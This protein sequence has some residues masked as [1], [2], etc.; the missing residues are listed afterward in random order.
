L[1]IGYDYPYSIDL[2]DVETGTYRVTFAGDRFSPAYDICFSPDGSLLASTALANTVSVWNTDT[3]DLVHAFPGHRSGATRSIHF[4]PDNVTLASGGADG[5]VK[6]WNVSSPEKSALRI[7]SEEHQLW[8]LQYSPDGGTLATSGPDGI[9]RLFDADTGD[10]IQSLSPLESRRGRASN[11][12]LSLQLAFSPDGRMLGA[13]NGDHTATV[14]SVD[15]GRPRFVLDGNTG[16]LANIRFAPN[17]RTIATTG[18]EDVMV[19]WDA[20]SGRELKRVQGPRL[21]EFLPDPRSQILAL[22]ERSGF[23]LL[24]LDT[25]ERQSVDVNQPWSL[26]FLENGLTLAVGF[27]GGLRLYSVPGLDL[28]ATLAVG[29]GPIPVVASSP[30]DSTLVIPSWGGV[31]DLWNTRVARGVGSLPLPV[32]WAISAQFSPDGNTLT[33][34]TRGAG[35]HQFRAPSWAQIKEWQREEAFQTQRVASLDREFHAEEQH[36]R[37]LQFAND[38]GSINQ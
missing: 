20:G 22:G 35:I 8:Y 32:D 5:T 21:V 24:D 10:L 1:A 7:A 6:L 16:P 15:S 3:F 36:R 37:E 2:W 25:G 23:S 38:P 18:E 9:V 34:S 33:V 14:Y 31:V 29:R 28:E 27:E 11:R 19:L 13:G 30:D 26:T 17:G 12:A 4:C